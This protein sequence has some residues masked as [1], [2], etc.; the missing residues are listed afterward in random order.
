MDIIVGRGLIEVRDGLYKADADELVML[1]YYARS[2]AHW[3][4]VENS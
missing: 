4:H 3:Q 1:A 2:I